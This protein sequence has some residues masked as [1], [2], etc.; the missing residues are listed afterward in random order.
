M[1]GS[2]ILPSL[3]AKLKYAVRSGICESFPNRNRADRRRSQ[4]RFLSVMPRA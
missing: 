4:G 2:N 3:V 1:A